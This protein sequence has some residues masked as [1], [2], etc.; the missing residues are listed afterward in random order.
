[1]NP[2]ILEPTDETP[3]VKLDKGADIFEISGKSLPEDVTSFYDPILDWLNT[4]FEAPNPTTNFRFNMLYFNT[5]SS[6]LIM[7]ILLMLEE[8]MEA[9]HEVA[10]TWCFMEDDEDMEEAGEEFSEIVDIPFKLQSN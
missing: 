6:K 5:A 1:M 8:K 9:G 4:Y 7:D 10:V 2:F 3:S